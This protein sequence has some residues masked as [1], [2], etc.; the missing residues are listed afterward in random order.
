MTKEQPFT[1]ALLAPFRHRVRRL[2]RALTLHRLSIHR[3]E[4]RQMLLEERIAAEQTVNRDLRGRLT[5]AEREIREL[6]IA[7]GILDS[8]S[9]SDS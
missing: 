1:T 5:T 9:S 7:L 3:L 8:F 2:G 6:R 4:D